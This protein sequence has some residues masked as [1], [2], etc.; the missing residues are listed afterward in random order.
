MSPRW[1]RPWRPRAPA[2]VE[3][4]QPV[5]AGLDNEVLKLLQDLERTFYA[6]RDA[7]KTF[8]W[9]ITEPKCA[10]QQYLIYLS[11][12]VD[13]TVSG[14]V[15][16]ALHNNARAMWMLSRLL[17]EYVAKAEYCD[18]NPDFALWWITVGEREDMLRRLKD[19]GSDAA[20]VKAAEQAVV[21]AKKKYA[22][23]SPFRKVRFSD[24]MISIAGKETYTSIYRDPSVFIHGDPV[25]MRDMFESVPGGVVGKIDFT[26]DRV[27]GLLVDVGANL[28]SFCNIYARNFKEV[29]S[30][31][32][33][34]RLSKLNDRIVALLRKY[35]EDRDPEVLAGLTPG[36]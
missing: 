17:V 12:L 35:P 13:L 4:R 22:D 28:L 16:L 11:M 20:T 23:D 2:A 3:C 5:R 15:M 25:G 36:P 26:D 31:D 18:Q 29:A 32:I 34:D 8:D 19:Y 7:A 14:T 9:A 21:D 24:M 27:N 1:S 10:V 6:T 33:P 30:S